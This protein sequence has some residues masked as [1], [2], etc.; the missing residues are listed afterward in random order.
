MKKL[1]VLMF[2]LLGIHL[3]TAAAPDYAAETK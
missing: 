1:A 2:G 3:M